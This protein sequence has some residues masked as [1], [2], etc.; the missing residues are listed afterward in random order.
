M[1]A[2]EREIIDYL[3]NKTLVWYDNLKFEFWFWLEY[4]M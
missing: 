4:G 2:E 3:G 1:Y